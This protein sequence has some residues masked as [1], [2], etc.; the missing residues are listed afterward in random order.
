MTGVPIKRGNLDRGRHIQRE[1]DVNAQREHLEAKECLRLPETRREV[2]NKQIL[3]CSPQKE[4]T[5]PP[6]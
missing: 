4:P 3:P 5:L 6:P 1:D 2:W